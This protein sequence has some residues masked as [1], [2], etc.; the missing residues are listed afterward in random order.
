[1]IWFT[2]A[3]DGRTIPVYYRKAYKKSRHRRKS[4]RLAPGFW[5][6]Y[7][8]CKTVKQEGENGNII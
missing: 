6:K 7:V 8:V 4:E 3:S 5:A 2:N 1:M